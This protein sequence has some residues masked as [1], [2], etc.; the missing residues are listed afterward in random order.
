MVAG[1]AGDD[2]MLLPCPTGCESI[3]VLAGP[4]LGSEDVGDGRRLKHTRDKQSK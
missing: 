4:I 2:V 3:E 1:M